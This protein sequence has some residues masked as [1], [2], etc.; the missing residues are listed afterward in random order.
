MVF[1]ARII[2]F[3]EIAVRRGHLKA[4]MPSFVPCRVEVQRMEEEREAPS[5]VR[6]AG[7]SG[8]LE[9]RELRRL[10]SLGLALARSNC[11]RR[12]PGVSSLWCFWWMC[13]VRLVFLR[14]GFVVCSWLS[15][16]GVG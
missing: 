3:V 5:C 7:V 15:G 9:R 11:L 16:L 13:W 4:R 1:R 12:L 6:M 8:A 10:R 14:F 2:F